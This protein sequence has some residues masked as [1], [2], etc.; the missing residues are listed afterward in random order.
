M[1]KYIWHYEYP[2]GKVGVGENDGAIAYIFFQDGPHGEEFIKKH[3][4]T[5]FELHE[6]ALIKKAGEQLR[7]YFAGIRREFDVPLVFK[8]TEFQK[9]VWLSLILIPYGETKTYGEIAAGIGNAK[10]ARAVGMANN[11]NPISI[12][13]PCHR[14]I[15][16]DGSLVGYGGGLKTKQFLLDLESGDA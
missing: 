7:E 15:G 8:G 10:A 13:C 3:G 4:I 1:G 9:K 14:V 16:S 6:S 2:I 11:R 12:I 5:D